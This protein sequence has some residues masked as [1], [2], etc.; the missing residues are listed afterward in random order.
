M[1]GQQEIVT[2]VLDRRDAMVLM[3]TGG[4]KSLC[5]Q[6]PALCFDGLTVVVSPL[7]A[8]MKDQVDKLVSNGV[9]AGFVNSSLT[10]AEIARLKDRASCQHDAGRI[11]KKNPQENQ[12][13]LKI[14]Y[15]AP[16][17]LALPEFRKFLQSLNVSLFAIDEA[18]CISEWGHDFRPDYRKLKSL[19][20]KFPA[21][22]MIALTAT[23]TERVRKDIVTQLGL[24]KPGV[25][26]SSF[27]RPN[28]TYNIYPKKNSFSALIKLLR[29]HDNGST[30]IYRVSRKATEEMAADLVANGFDAVPYHAGLEPPLRR[31]TQEKFIRGETKIIVAT[32]AFGMGIDKADIRLVVH[33]DL[34]K[35]LEGYYQETGRAGRDGLPSECALFFSYGDKQK[36]EFFISQIEDRQE[37][38]SARLRLDQVVELCQIQSCRRKHLLNY[39]GEKWDEDYCGGCDVC[40]SPPGASEEFDATRILQIVLSTV[41][42]TGERFGAAHV[43]N[44]LQGT[45]NQKVK[46]WGHQELSVFGVG[47]SHTTDEL[48][49][50]I[51]AFLATGLIA[52]SEDSFKTVTVTEKGRAFL[53]TNETLILNKP[54]A[55]ESDDSE[56][57][58]KGV[59]A[60]GS[61]R[62]REPHGGSDR[63]LFEKLRLLRRSIA[64]ERSKPAY[65]I[66]SDATLWDMV[67]R[68]PVSR[69]SF[70]Q[71][72]GVGSVKLEEFADAFMEVIEAHVDQNGSKKIVNPD[73]KPRSSVYRAKDTPSQ[74]SS[75]VHRTKELVE[76]KLSVRD[77]AQQRGLTDNT[78]INHIARLVVEGETLDLDHLL[79][80]KPQLENILSAF[81]Q[82]SGTQ[83][84]PVWELMEN[85]H[86]YE[87]LALARIG[88]LQ[89]GAIILEGDKLSLA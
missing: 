59:A 25:F 5:Y 71:V 14:L 56:N 28:L 18:H 7:I 84:T 8:L 39:F 81:R 21:V 54:K 2:A 72:S 68:Q 29:D 70:S 12:Q 32:I 40:S 13:R 66:F 83:L 38:E 33:Y 80:S 27:N 87:E 62:N 85:R 89:Q 67:D 24:R 61:Q 74:P 43:I 6:L 58:T 51:Q 36:Q 82:S 57:T 1:P 47:K 41:I 49:W 46:S 75:T 73:P 64:E 79:P 10:A 78:I 69:G 16:E 60:K 26:T 76:Q 53:K 37:Q 22:P 42:R 9:P 11:D 55:A 30:I 3:P 31:D 15:V 44:V 88:L 23:A 34:P 77:I 48:R 4:G 63:E 50:A 35:S 65:V 45:G 86:T 19:R 17:R 52:R 20:T